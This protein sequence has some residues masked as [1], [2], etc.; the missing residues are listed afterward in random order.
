M[1]SP[2]KTVKKI[3]P[4]TNLRSCLFTGDQPGQMLSDA[5]LS[6]SSSP[7]QEVLRRAKAFVSETAMK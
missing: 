7:A 4:W 3:K 5:A 1:D 2:C 6:R